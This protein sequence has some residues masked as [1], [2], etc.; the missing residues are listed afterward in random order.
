MKVKNHHNGCQGMNV[1]FI[2]NFKGMGLVYVHKLATGYVITKSHTPS[3]ERWIEVNGIDHFK[4]IQEINE[5]L[6]ND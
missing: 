1:F 5:A 6:K 2:S 3:L 4:S